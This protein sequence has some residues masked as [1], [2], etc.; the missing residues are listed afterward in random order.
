M[1]ASTDVFESIT[2]PFQREVENKRFINVSIKCY[3]KRSGSGFKEEYYAYRIV[4]M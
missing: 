3:E 1:A 4:A 2:S